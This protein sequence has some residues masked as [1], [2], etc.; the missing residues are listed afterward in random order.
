MDV[1]LG[2]MVKKSE[3]KSPDIGSLQGKHLGNGLIELRWK[4]GDGV[5]HRIGGF[6]SA[7]NVFIMLAGWTHNKRKYV[8]PSV[9]ESGGVLINRMKTLT[10]KEASTCEYSVVNSRRAK[11]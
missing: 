6:I 8:P 9:L 1:F 11:R 3:W 5:P 4:S 7:D 2:I 10:S